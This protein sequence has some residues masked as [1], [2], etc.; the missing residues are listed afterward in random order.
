MQGTDR[1]PTYVLVVLVVLV[2]LAVPVVLA[3][4]ADRRASVL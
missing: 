2:A 3:V 1:Q 4:L